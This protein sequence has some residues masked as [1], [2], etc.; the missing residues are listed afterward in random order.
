MTAK[1][2]Y[3]LFK[4]GKRM[5][6]DYFIALDKETLFEMMEAFADMKNNTKKTISQKKKKTL[7]Y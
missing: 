3:K 1:D 2:L 7:M 6:N 5:E 4:R